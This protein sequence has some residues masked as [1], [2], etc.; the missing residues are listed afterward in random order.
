MIELRGGL[1]SIES[2]TYIRLSLFWIELNIC[3][4][5]DTIPRYPPPFHLIKNQYSTAHESY[6]LQ[7]RDKAIG[8]SGVFSLLSS[9]EMLDIFTELSF[10]TV[11]L[12]AESPLRVS[13]DADNFPGFGFYPTLHKLLSIQLASTQDS[14]GS[15]VQEMCRLGA[16]LFLAEVRR[17]FGISP[18]V[19]SV[20]SSKLHTLLD[21]NEMLWATELDTIRDWTI[22][23]AGCAADTEADRTRAVQ[24]LIQSSIVLDYRSVDGLR[25]MASKMWWIDEVFLSKSQELQSEYINLL[26]R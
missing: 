5:Q 16:I 11:A 15:A 13:W 14:F 1:L 6:G 22:L 25:N 17:K 18:V 12:T 7:H 10:L 23:M 24:S 9:T 19:T 4:A 3:A 20:Q 21:N 2:A 26:N 8:A